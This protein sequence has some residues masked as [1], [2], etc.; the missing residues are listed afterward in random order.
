M[1]RLNVTG[2]G[3]HAF[4]DLGEVQQLDAVQW[5]ID[6]VEHNNHINDATWKFWHD[7]DDIITTY[8]PAVNTITGEFTSYDPDEPTQR[9]TIEE[10]GRKILDA[11][12][13]GADPLK[14]MNDWSDGIYDDGASRKP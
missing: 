5:L 1:T 9:I 7:A 11:C 14:L 10:R 3:M 12:I 8:E 13:A 4:S 2:D 6:Y